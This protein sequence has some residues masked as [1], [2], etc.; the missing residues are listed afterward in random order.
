MRT[1]GPLAQNKGGS[2][3]SSN[4]VKGSTPHTS[5]PLPLSTLAFLAL[6]LNPL[7]A[8]PCC[9]G[10]SAELNSPKLEPTNVSSAHWAAQG[11]PGGFLR[12]PSRGAPRALAVKIV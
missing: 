8:G 4:R 5:L 10:R 1:D 2:N 3:H 6:L 11:V 7:R 9:E 12:R